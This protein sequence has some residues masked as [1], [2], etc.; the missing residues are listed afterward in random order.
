MEVQRFNTVMIAF[1]YWRISHYHLTDFNLRFLSL[2]SIH[3]IDLVC[4]CGSVCVLTEF[5]QP[6]SFGSPWLLS[7]QQIL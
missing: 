5:L 6:C 3:T 4:V 1:S 7:E 2:L